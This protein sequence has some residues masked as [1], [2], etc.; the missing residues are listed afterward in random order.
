LTALKI[1]TTM[2]AEPNRWVPSWWQTSGPFPVAND[3]GNCCRLSS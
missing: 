1:Q 3:S 2:L